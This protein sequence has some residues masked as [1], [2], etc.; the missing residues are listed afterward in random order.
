MPEKTEDSQSSGVCGQATARPGPARSAR[1]VLLPQAQAAGAARDF[2]RTTC[3]RWGLRAPLDEALLVV[4]ELVT[5]A[6]RHAGSPLTLHLLARPDHLRVEVED[7]APGLPRMR[8]SA[9]T[10]FGGRGLALVE[11]VSRQ[12][13]SSPCPTGKVVWATLALTGS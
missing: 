13:G 2:T 7:Q 10:D 11:A 4:S 3:T 9:S 5:N 12:W 8:Q 6:V 1:L